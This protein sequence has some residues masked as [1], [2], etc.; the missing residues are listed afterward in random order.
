MSKDFNIEDEA[1]RTGSKAVVKQYFNVSVIDN[2]LDIRFY[3]AGRGTTV[4]PKRGDYGILISAISVCSSSKSHC[5]EHTKTW[6]PLV[7]GIIASICL[8]FLVIGVLAWRRY[9]RNKYR[10]EKSDLTGLELLTGS[11]SLR[12]LR[13]ATNNFDSENK[14]GEGG[15]GSVYKGQLSDG[16]V[17][18]VKKMSSKSGQGN[19]EFVTEIGMISGLQ[20]PNLVKLYGCC[21]EGD[22]L[23]LVYEYMENNCL[24]RALFGPGTSSPKLDWAT[25]FNICVGIANGLYFLHEGSPLKI[26]HRDIKAT[27]VLLDRDLNAK[28]SDFGLAKLHEDNNT[29][30]S[31][32]VA[33]TIGYMAPEYALWGCLTE[34]ADVYS[35]GVVALEIVSGKSNTNYRP[36]NECVCLLDYAFVLQQKEELLEI[37]DENLDEI[38]KEQAERVIKVAL[39]CTNASPM[40]RPT[41]FDVVGMLEGR[42][43]VQEVVSDPGI[44]GD[45]LGKDL[46]FKS[47]KAYYQEIQNKDTIVAQGSKLTSDKPSTSTSAND[48]YPI[49][50]ESLTISGN[51]LYEI[52]LESRNINSDF[53]SDVT[54]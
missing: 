42:I 50:P 39:L 23:L 40:M 36:Q 15:F 10:R 37:V 28:I 1:I 33:G 7:A 51:D 47:L 31:T 24:G 9:R 21:I 43:E 27:N 2:T 22:E 4:I 46:R 19:R 49:N 48:L 52:N 8:I 35:F 26:V 3:W 38:N 29:H 18:A 41:M 54:S 16:T 34:K 17:I 53:F 20:H 45:V 5:E 30:I 11:F 25:R 6:I 13:V 32:R 44:Y 12:Q 14:I